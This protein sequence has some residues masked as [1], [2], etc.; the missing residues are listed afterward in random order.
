VH[1]GTLVRLWE[2]DIDGL[3]NRLPSLLVNPL[4]SWD[5]NWPEMDVKLIVD[6][7]KGF[8]LCRFSVCFNDG[9]GGL[10]CFDDGCG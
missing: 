4:G 8:C 6:D 3:H 10:D 7:A 2:D 1:E 9:P 5:V